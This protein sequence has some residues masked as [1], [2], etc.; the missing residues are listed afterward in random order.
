MTARP[1][2]DPNYIAAPVRLMNVFI[3]K[4][5]KTFTVRS[6]IQVSIDLV[7]N[8]KQT[9]R[10]VLAVKAPLKPNSRRVL[11]LVPDWELRNTPNSVA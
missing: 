7:S 11:V 5:K 10:Q 4:K 1:K 3:S 9:K 6:Y 2:H 8:G